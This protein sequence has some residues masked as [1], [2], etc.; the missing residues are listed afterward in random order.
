MPVTLE[1][2]AEGIRRA[3]AAGDVDTVRKLG[4]A[5]R[6][7][8]AGGNDGPPAGAQP[9]SK[10]YADWALAQARAGKELPQ[11]SQHTEFQAPQPNGLMDKAHVAAGSFLEGMPLVG[12]TLIDWAKKGRSAVQGMSPEQVNAEYEA[13]KAANP[14]TSTAAG[15]G[16]SIAALAPLG[17]TQI[18]GR[19]LGMTGGFGS[20]LGMGVLSGGTLSGADALTRGATP[21]E[22]GA[23]ALTGGA[24]GAAFPL[25]GAAFR[26]AVSPLAKSP[27]KNPAATLL[28][29]EGVDLT[30]GQITGSKGLRYRES[31]LGGTAA[32]N[33]ME[34][35]AKQFT[36]A[37]LR[38][39]GINADEAS[40]DVIDRA[41]TDIGGMFDDLASRNSLAPDRKL[42][43]DLQ[44]AWRRFEG[45]TNPQ[46]RPKVIE[47]LITDIYGKGN[48][49]AMSGQWY[50]STR[51]E[52]GRLTRSANPELS[53]AARDMQFALDDAMERTLAKTNPGDAAA[54]K[55]ARRL[56]KNMLV[57][58]DAATRAGAQAAD[59]VITP[60]ALRSAAIRQNKRA[61]AR[62][63]NDFTDLA[64]AGVKAMTPLPDSGTPGRLSAKT[65]LPLGA[66]T[67]AGVGG[68]VGGLPGAAIGGLAGAVA[69]WAVGKA[70]LSGPGRAY[71]SNGALAGGRALPAIAPAVLPLEVTK[72][73]EP[74]QITVRGGAR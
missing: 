16:G 70:M 20:R 28:K 22:A 2:L 69:P 24:L 32:Q 26:K 21:Q 11:V 13:E 41:F 66:A 27:A 38:R 5:Y 46:T 6:Q 39:A 4:A 3:N 61:F 29:Q 59:G 47:R 63:R 53:E 55:E 67:G 17:A 64:D 8:Q 50:Q 56:Y 72:K 14:I 74:I 54:W 1:R 12:S 15:I 68:T 42:A 57:V 34:R 43:Q 73:R 23:A 33:F 71:L 60:Q 18:G 65:V 58:E 44:S 30:A 49:G 37:A 36:A 45:S 62:G 10:A 52:L 7:M 40:H 25:A 48:S 51:S 35:Q 19:L 9:G 31:E